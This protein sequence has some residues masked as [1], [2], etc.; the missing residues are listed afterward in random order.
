M[1]CVSQSKFSYAVAYVLSESETL[2]RHQHSGSVS[3]VVFIQRLTDDVNVTSEPVIMCLQ[4]C[5]TGHY[6]S[7]VLRSHIMCR[8]PSVC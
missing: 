8:L 2:T 7:A 3:F 4:Y 5:P 1:Y 6:A